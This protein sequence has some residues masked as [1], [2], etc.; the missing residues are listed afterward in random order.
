[1]LLKFAPPQ[2]DAEEK[3]VRGFCSEELFIKM[4]LI[5]HSHAAREH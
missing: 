5:S 1:V 3:G 2:P 4:F